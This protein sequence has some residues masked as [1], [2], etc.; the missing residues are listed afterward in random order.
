V[1]A[2]DVGLG[3]VVAA[4]RGRAGER[5]ILGGDNLTHRRALEIVASAVGK[6]GP[7][8]TL[9]PLP[10][11]LIAAAVRWISRL[12]GSSLPFSAEQVWLS[13]REIYCDSSKAVEELGFVQTPFRT[14]V[15]RA[16][17][18]YRARRMLD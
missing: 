1:D 4:E 14:S 18:W 15:E 8:A 12:S 5:Y 16:Y 2:I 7:I 13:T 10:M 9:H 6:R 3:H 17:S 11:E